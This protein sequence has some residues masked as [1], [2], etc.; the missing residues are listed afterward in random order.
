[1][2]DPKQA[3]SLTTLQT[4]VG[5]YIE[6]VS[7]GPF[8]FWCDEEGKLKG[9]PINPLATRIWH[10]LLTQD[11]EF[12]EWA[13][14]DL[15]V[16]TVFVTGVTDRNGYETSLTDELVNKFVDIVEFLQVGHA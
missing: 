15:L 6:A 14:A 8:T 10:H 12:S 3:F 11:S 4:E 13:L 2:T 7:A 16:G 5:G 9:K 1:M